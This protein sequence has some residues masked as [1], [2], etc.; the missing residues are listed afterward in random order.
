MSEEPRR[1]T[2]DDP[3]AWE[4]YWTAQGMPWRTEPEIDEERQAY[5]VERRAISPNIKK[6]VYPLTDVKLDRADVEWLLATHESGGMRGPV[7]WEDVAQRKRVGLDLRGADLQGVDLSNLP[8]ARL[9]GGLTGNDYDLATPEQNAAAALH[10]S[11]TSLRYAR[12]EAAVLTN[13]H[14]EGVNLYAA[15]LEGADLYRAHLEADSPADLRLAVFDYATTLHF[16]TLSNGRRIGP[17]L[18]G[19]HWD[20]VNL[21][22]VDWSKVRRLDDE[23]RARTGTAGGPTDETLYLPLNAYLHAVQANRQLATVMRNQGISEDASR[24]EYRAQ[25]L[26]RQVLRQQ[27]RLGQAVGSWLL[28]ML[29]GL[30]TATSP[31]AVW[32]RTSW[33]FSGSPQPTSR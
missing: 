15:H 29:A 9:Q 13:G 6:G 20:S 4:A 2:G 22:L 19:V 10:M 1:P 8:L 32:S 16:V 26:Q 27:G 12:L 3:D 33:L 30:A 11:G 17:R 31:C 28:D 14:L 7:D 5:L 21:S 25:V 23:H 24:F 18:S